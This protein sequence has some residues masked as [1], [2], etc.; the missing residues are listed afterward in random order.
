MKNIDLDISFLQKYISAIQM[1]VVFEILP[2]IQK[3]AETFI[4]ITPKQFL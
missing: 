1:I 4:K 3:S 2:R